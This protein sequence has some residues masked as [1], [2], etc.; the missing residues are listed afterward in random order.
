MIIFPISSTIS[1]N[2]ADTRCV[3][4]LP[5]VKQ[6]FTETF[7]ARSTSTTPRTFAGNINQLRNTLPAGASRGGILPVGKELLSV[8]AGLG[9][10][11]V[12]LVVVRNVE[13]VNVFAGLLNRRFFLFVR[14]FCA[15]DNVCVSSLTPFSVVVK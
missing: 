1:S 8:G 15:A 11:L 14:D 13:V 5:Q 2:T 7:L 12:S 9:A 6:N 3:L 10:K 4:V